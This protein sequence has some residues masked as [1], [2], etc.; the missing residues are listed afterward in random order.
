MRNLPRHPFWPR[1][2]KLDRR[3]VCKTCDA[4]P[5]CRRSPAAA[6]S[7]TL[8]VRHVFQIATVNDIL[9]GAACALICRYRHLR[10]A[11]AQGLSLA[12][13]NDVLPGAA[14][15]LICSYTLSYF[16][17]AQRP[18]ESCCTA[19]S[20]S[21]WTLI[22]GRRP[23]NACWGC[24]AR[25][26]RCPAPTAAARSGRSGRRGCCPRGDPPRRRPC[27][28]TQAGS[29]WLVFLHGGAKSHHRHF[30]ALTL[31]VAA[32]FIL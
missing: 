13:V 25:A 28:V 15:A 23:R 6:A 5:P 4:H 29:R 14:G 12:A 17:C 3:Q 22:C 31:H 24:L 30:P 26:A 7:R 10:F 1:P 18:W 19:G 9:P 20:C 21:H 27:S 11:S 8:L 32:S 16:A 2:N